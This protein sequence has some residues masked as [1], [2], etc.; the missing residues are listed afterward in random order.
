MKHL[1]KTILL[2]LPV[3]ILSLNLSSCANAVL[4]A[5]DPRS[6]ATVTNDN[7]TAQN[8]NFAY[9]ESGVYGDLT[10]TV[11]NHKA[12]LTGRV[13][14]KEQRKNA[15]TIAYSNKYIS[16]V[17]NYL[18]VEDAKQYQASTINDSYITA[19][20][21]TDLF[22]TPGVSSNNVKLVTSGGVVYIFGLVPAKQEKTI[23]N[24]ARSMSGVNNVVM[25]VERQK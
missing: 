13:S 14:T 9:A 15:V 7:E 3:V 4:V 6:I 2:G 20:V 10:V 12:L 25:L 24:Q 22:S 17:Y 16:K 1:T 18:V 11:Y 23:Y 8:L 19:K 5:T 21:K